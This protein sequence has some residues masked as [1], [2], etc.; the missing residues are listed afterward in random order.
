VRAE[1]KWLLLPLFAILLLFGLLLALA[2]GSS[3]APF[4]YAAF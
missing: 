4:I 2:V 3:M 1:G